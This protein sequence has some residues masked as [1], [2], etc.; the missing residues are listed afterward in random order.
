VFKTFIYFTISMMWN[1]RPKE[2]GH[3]QSTDMVYEIIEEDFKAITD[4]NY[5]SS[6]KCDS[7][8]ENSSMCLGWSN[9][10]RANI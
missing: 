9:I 2:Q 6:W 3:F 1:T 7:T 4:A 8:K 10:Q 5:L